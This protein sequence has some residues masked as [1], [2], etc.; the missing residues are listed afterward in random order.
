MNMWGMKHDGKKENLNL[1]NIY[2]D[3]QYPNQFA[4][5]FK[6]THKNKN[7]LDYCTKWVHIRTEGCSRKESSASIKLNESWHPSSLKNFHSHVHHI[8]EGHQ[9]MGGLWYFEGGEGIRGENFGKLIFQPEEGVGPFSEHGC[10]VLQNCLLPHHCLAQSSQIIG[11]VH[12]R[13]FDTSLK[14][15]DALCICLPWKKHHLQPQCKCKYNLCP[16]SSKTEFTADKLGITSHFCLYGSK[17]GLFSYCCAG[18]GMF[19][20]AQLLTA[21][22]LNYAMWDISAGSLAMGNALHVRLRV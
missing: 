1:Y 22:A 18:F 6:S 9:L 5:N 3:S 11:L 16:E 2:D 7:Q 19:R 12:K 10:S 21:M 17:L 4:I 14:G 20:P 13:T 15:L 8:I